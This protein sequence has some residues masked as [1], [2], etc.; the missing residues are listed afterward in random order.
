MTY[1]ELIYACLDLCKIFS[2]DSTINEEHIIFLANKYRLFLLEQKYKSG[3]LAIPS[4][5]LQTI[6]LNMEQY[7]LGTCEDMTLR[8]KEVIPAISNLTTPDVLLSTFTG[9]TFIPFERFQYVNYNRFLRSIIYAAIG[10][11]NHIYFKSNNTQFLYIEEAKLTGIF[12]NAEE[13]SNMSCDNDTNCDIYDKEYPL[14]TALLPQLIQSVLKDILGANYRPS[15]EYNNARDD[16]ANL[17]TFIRNNT[18]NNLQKQMD[19]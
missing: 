7:S 4:S 10:R 16:L 15:D 8:S 12:E 5:N 9:I 14:E 3:K 2:D 1:R 18:K 13:A 6:C 11:D 19:E 17:M